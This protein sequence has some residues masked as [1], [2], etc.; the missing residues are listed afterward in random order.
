MSPHSLPVLA[1]RD[2][3]LPL[4]ESSHEPTSET[5]DTWRSPRSASTYFVTLENGLSRA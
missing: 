4:A 2:R 3:P 5:S 1:A